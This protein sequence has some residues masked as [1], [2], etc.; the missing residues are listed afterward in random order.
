M[1][2]LVKKHLIHTSVIVCLVPNGIATAYRSFDLKCLGCNCLGEDPQVRAPPKQAL[3]ALRKAKFYIWWHRKTC[4][5]NV[6]FLNAIPHKSVFLIYTRIGKLRD[7]TM[8]NADYYRTAQ[9]AVDIKIP[10]EA[11]R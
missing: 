2:A 6:Y 8:K 11:I 9:H 1:E 3:C 4:E 10:L 7:Q 5:E